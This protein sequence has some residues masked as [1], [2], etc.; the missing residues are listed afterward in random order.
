MTAINLLK[1]SEKGSPLD[2]DDYDDNLTII[3]TQT[4]ATNEKGVANGYASLGAG[5]LVPV[6]QLGSGTPTGAKFLRDDGAFATPASGGTAP[7]ALEISVTGAINI[8]GLPSVFVTLLAGSATSYTASSFTG[9]FPGQI[10]TLYNAKVAATAV[11]SPGFATE[12]GFGLS[13]GTND[14][15]TFVCNPLNNFVQITPKLT[16]VG[17]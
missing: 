6:A 14:I 4:Q 1:R 16:A 7:A 15:C 3:E 2:A 5:G 8:T 10:L 13:F 17:F 11:A 9:R 12:G